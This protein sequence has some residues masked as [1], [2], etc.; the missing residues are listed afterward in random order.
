MR[1][2]FGGLQ[3][4]E[5]ELFFVREDGGREHIIVFKRV[6]EAVQE[7]YKEVVRL[8]GLPFPLWDKPSLAVCSTKC[9]F[10][11]QSFVMSSHL[12]KLP[13]RTRPASSDQ[14]FTPHHTSSDL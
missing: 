3:Q 6:Q 7:R 12:V 1:H 8:G 13:H 5:R 11:C 14:T 10:T 2:G 4:S 9:P